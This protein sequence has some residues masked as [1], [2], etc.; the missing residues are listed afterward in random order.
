LA[1]IETAGKLP[2]TADLPPHTTVAK[3]NAIPAVGVKKILGKKV[4]IRYYLFGILS[5]VAQSLEPKLSRHLLS[6]LP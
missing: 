4:G 3:A 2:A 1:T 5:I 6:K